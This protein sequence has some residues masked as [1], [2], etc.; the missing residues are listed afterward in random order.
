MTVILIVE[1]VKVLAKKSQ[2][3]KEKWKSGGKG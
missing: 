1:G 2:Y 3:R